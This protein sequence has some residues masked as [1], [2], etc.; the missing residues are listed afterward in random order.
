MFFLKF[1]FFKH[2]C[3]PYKHL[4]SQY[5]HL[6]CTPYMV[7]IKILKTNIIQHSHSWCTYES[8]PFTCQ[9][10][11]CFFFFIYLKK[12]SKTANQPTHWLKHKKWL[13]FYFKITIN[14]YLFLHYLFLRCDDEMLHCWKNEDLN[15]FT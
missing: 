4:D 6:A 5:S 15:S 8:I 7:N 1:R 3:F 9:H 14:I 10:G 13:Y 12:I 11:Q 2:K